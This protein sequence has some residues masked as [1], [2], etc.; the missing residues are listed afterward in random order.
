METLKF[1]ESIDKKNERVR[2]YSY[3]DKQIYSQNQ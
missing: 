1:S 3:L 2:N